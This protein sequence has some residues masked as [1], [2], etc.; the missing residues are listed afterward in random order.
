MEEERSAKETFEL[1]KNVSTMQKIKEACNEHGIRQETVK[2]TANEV[3]ITFTA[4][5]KKDIELI[6]HMYQSMTKTVEEVQY[7]AEWVR[8]KE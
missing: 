5:S 4:F 1:K 7:P 2:E 6:K 8:P 3:V